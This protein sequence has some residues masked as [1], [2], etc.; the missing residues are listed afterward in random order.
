MKR[1]NILLSYFSNL[2]KLL[3]PKGVALIGVSLVATIVLAG[4][5]YLIAIWMI[6]FLFILKIRSSPK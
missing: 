3:S 5:E 4:A 1:E 6:V 2:R